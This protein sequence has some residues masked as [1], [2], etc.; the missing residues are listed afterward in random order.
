MDLTNIINRHFADHALAAK[1]TCEQL[2]PQIAAAAELITGQL[3]TE[4]KVL[5]CGNGAGASD[6]QSFAASML[7]RFEMERS[8]LPA[9]ALTADVTTLTAIANDYQYPEVFSKPIRALGQPGDILLVI[10]TGGDSPN[11]VAAIDAA[12]EREM[13]VILLSGRDG[14]AAASTLRETDIELRVPPCPV[15]RIRE[16]HRIMLNTL[17]DLIDRQLFGHED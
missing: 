11:I 3:I 4:H 16:V 9:V 10:T 15:P 13:S 17:S 8:G 2:A 6:A 1:L 7:N 5:A 12:H 14:G